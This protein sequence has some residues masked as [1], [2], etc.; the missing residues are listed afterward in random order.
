MAPSCSVGWPDAALI[1][2]ARKRR[3]GYVQRRMELLYQQRSPASSPTGP[4][5]RN[6]A[7]AKPL[8]VAVIQHPGACQRQ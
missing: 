2:S 8:V 3:V 7:L 5:N 4:Y 1:G 6:A